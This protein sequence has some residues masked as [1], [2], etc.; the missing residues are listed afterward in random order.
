MG[1]ASART[2]AGSFARPRRSADTSTSG[3]AGGSYDDPWRGWRW[4]EVRSGAGAAADY[5]HVYALAPLRSSWD[6]AFACI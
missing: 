1:N 6:L 5:V 2:P 4:T 3:T